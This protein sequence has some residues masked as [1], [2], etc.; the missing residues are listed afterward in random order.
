MEYLAIEKDELAD[1]LS[2]ANKLFALERGGVDNWP[3]Y[4]DSLGDYLRSWAVEYDLDPDED[5][6]FADIAAEDI[7]RYPTVEKFIR[8]KGE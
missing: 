8:H 6:D 2:A 7:K 3:W 1:L 4:G 5:W